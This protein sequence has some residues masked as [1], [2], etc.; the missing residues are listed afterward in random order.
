MQLPQPSAQESEEGERLYRAGLA[1][2]HA[3]VRDEAGAID[4][5]REAGGLHHYLAL[6][7]LSMALYERA[8]RIGGPSAPDPA[9]LD[10]AAEAG[11][12]GHAIAEYRLGYVAAAKLHL[13]PDRP[14]ARRGDEHTAALLQLASRLG[15]KHAMQMLKV[16][17]RMEAGAEAA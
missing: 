2:W 12:W 10:A 11:Y 4:R 14:D 15:D 16:L 3:A 6:C 9:L 5:W 13:R 1:C 17:A 8:V 7:A